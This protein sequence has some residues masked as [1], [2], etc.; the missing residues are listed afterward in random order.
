MSWCPISNVSFLGYLIAHR[1][2]VWFLV[3]L[4]DCNLSFTKLGSQATTCNF[5]NAFGWFQDWFSSLPVKSGRWCELL[6][7]VLSG[8]RLQVRQILEKE[9][10]GSKSGLRLEWDRSRGQRVKTAQLHYAR[11]GAFVFSR[12]PQKTQAELK[13]WPRSE[14]FCSPSEA[15]ESSL[16]H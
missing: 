3:P 4:R 10:L 9:G 14:S 5:F 12:V 7:S 15:S 2:S 6:R 11:V 16:F 13:L 1:L 8:A